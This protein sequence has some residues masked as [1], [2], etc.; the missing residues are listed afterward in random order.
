MTIVNSLTEFSKRLLIGI[1]ILSLFAGGLLF[2]VSQSGSTAI[3]GTKE[4]SDSEKGV[5]GFRCS[6]L[7]LRGRYAVHGDGWVPNGPPGTPMVPFAVLSLMTLD[8]QG[9]VVDDA[10]ISRNGDTLRSVNAGT[11]SIDANCKG[12]MSV[13]IPVPPFLLTFDVVITD[14]GKEFYFISTNGSVRIHEARVLE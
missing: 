9:N 12:T 13:N 11:Y 6:D 3:A 4:L 1:G 7:T 8:G 2:L 10:T 14:A 5:A